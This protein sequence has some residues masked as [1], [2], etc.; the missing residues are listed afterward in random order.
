MKIIDVKT[1]VL[2]GY[3]PQGMGGKPREWQLIVVKI[4]T[5]AGISGIG[6]CPHWQRNYFGVRETIEYLAQRLIGKSPFEV[7]KFVE[8]H[9]NGA[10]PPHEPRTLPATILPVGPVVWA[11]SGIEMALMDIVGKFCNVPVS[12]ILGGKFRPKVPIYLDRSGPQDVTSEKQWEELA[13]DT[14]ARGFHRFKFDI[15][16]V[17]PDFVDDVWARTISRKQMNAIEKRLTASR[18]AAGDDAEISVDCHMHYDVP[19]S[20]ELAKVLENLNISW[21]EDPTPVMDI[22]ALSEIRD[23]TNIPI[24][25]GEM[26]NV[27]MAKQFIDA[28][29]LDIIHPDIL[30]AGGIHQTRKICELAEMSRIPVAFHN[31]STALGLV[32][33]CQLGSTIPNVIAAEYHFYDSEW[34]KDWVTRN[35][36]A[37]FVDGHVVVD[38]TPGLGCELNEKKCLELLAPGEKFVG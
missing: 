37:L 17:A 38:D 10:R 5:D 19:S 11:M 35:Q 4:F 32:A 6:E 1:M 24:C 23:R 14:M 29:A 20:I 12:T 16:H 2:K 13:A 18:R 7:K 15:D 22:D 36:G 34:S 27:E 8:E 9:F 21:L 25:A 26:F 3:D 30:F 33:T 28:R 31:N